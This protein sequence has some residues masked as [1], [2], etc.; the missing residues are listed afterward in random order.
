MKYALGIAAALVALCVYASPAAA[1]GPG[2]L[3]CSTPGATTPGNYAGEWR[4]RQHDDG[5]DWIDIAPHIFNSNGT[6]SETSSA[7]LKYGQWCVV[8]NVLIWGFDADGD[9]NRTTYR[10][11]IGSLPMRGAM[12]WHDGG[13][14]EV[15][16]QR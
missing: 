14:G 11:P 9:G 13:T 2:P 4:I 7:G 8:G 6:F 12:S 16:I 15:E 5:Y 1:A 10:V 3:A